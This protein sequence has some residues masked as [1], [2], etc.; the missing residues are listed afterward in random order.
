MILKY[1]NKISVF[2]LIIA[3]KIYQI[4]FSPLL[5]FNCRYLPTY[6]EYS[7]TVLKDQGLINGL[8]YTFKRILSCH[9][10]GGHGYDPIPKKIKK[11]L[12]NG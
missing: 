12:Y 7:I 8:Y 1:L 11:D 10:F 2:F 9:P 4:F 5:R 6:S 3:I